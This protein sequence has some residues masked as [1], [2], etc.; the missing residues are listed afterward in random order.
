MKARLIM[1]QTGYM[2]LASA[3]DDLARSGFREHFQMKA[4]KLLALDSGKT[5]NAAELVIRAY[6]R[7]EGVSD[8]DDMAIVYAI[9]SHSGVRGTLVDAFGVYADPAV[10]VFLEGVPIRK[11]AQVGAL[12]AAQPRAVGRPGGALTR[13]PMREPFVFGPRDHPIAVGSLAATTPRTA[14]YDY[15]FPVPLSGDPWQDD[16]GED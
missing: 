3:V 14:R 5:F 16:G 15:G 10:G 11:A 12:Q 2:T 9:E 1:A 4:G 7:F 6:H 13:R 8:P